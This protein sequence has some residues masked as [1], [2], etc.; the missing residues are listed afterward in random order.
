MHGV[1]S[2]AQFQCGFSRYSEAMMDE[3]RS[4]SR[5]VGDK[6]V[7]SNLKSGM[8]LFDQRESEWGHDVVCSKIL[9]DF[10]KIIAR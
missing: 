8:T 4:C 9:A 7:K 5:Q 3:A 1:L 2:R 10:P 6:A